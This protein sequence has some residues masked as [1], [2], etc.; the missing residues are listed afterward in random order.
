MEGQIIFLKLFNKNHKEMKPVVISFLGWTLKVPFSEG[1][2]L[3]LPTKF[4]P[5]VRGRR[6]KFFPSIKGSNIAKR[7]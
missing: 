3:K 7:T 5:S 4:F 1:S 6:I 2:T